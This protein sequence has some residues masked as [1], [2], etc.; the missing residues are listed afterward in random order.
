MAEVGILGLA[1][2]VGVKKMLQTLNLARHSHQTLGWFAPMI[3]VLFFIFL[4]LAMVDHYLF[5][6]QAGL[7]LVAIA[8]MLFAKK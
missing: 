7:L 2:I 6:V 8:P 1:A 4:P 5:T 3:P